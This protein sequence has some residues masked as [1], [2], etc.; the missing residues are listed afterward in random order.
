MRL[1]TLL[2]VLSLASCNCGTAE[3]AGC[4]EN[5]IHFD[6]GDNFTAA[7]GCN[8]CVCG[9]NGQVVCTEQACSS[10]VDGGVGS[11]AARDAGPGNIVEPIPSSPCEVV[12]VNGRT[13]G[14]SLAPGDVATLTASGFE[15][16]NP[17]AEISTVA[18]SLIRSPVGSRAQLSAQVGH[19]TS[20]IGEPT[21]GTSGQ[22]GPRMAGLYGLRAELQD[23]QGGN[24]SADCH[25]LLQPTQAL[26][27]DLV[28]N[29]GPA[30]YDLRL[31]KKDTADRF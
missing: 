5:G 12:A 29:R 21:D 22:R 1:T 24:A 28:W 4:D 26:Y 2:L 19:E 23:D 9:D 11:D 13:P 20:L 8:R 27:V 10:N 3:R 31:A 25:I 16:A 7:D 14:T 15:P 30:D 6:V 17:G 18:W